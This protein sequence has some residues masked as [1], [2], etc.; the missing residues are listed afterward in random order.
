MFIHLIKVAQALIKQK[1]GLIYESVGQAEANKKANQELF[2]AFVQNANS[3]ESMNKL[4]EK[5]EG[6]GISKED[7]DLL[8]NELLE[9]QNDPILKLEIS[10]RLE[11]QNTI[12]T[13]QKKEDLEQIEYKDFSE[14]P[15]GIV[16]IINENEFSPSS[17]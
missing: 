13:P 10:A 15:K 8:K 7:I 1:Y 11:A 9:I 5:L 4:L 14:Y 16:K 3:E 2:E 17:E 6:E 12:F